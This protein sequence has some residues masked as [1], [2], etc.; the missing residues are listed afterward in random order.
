MELQTKSS[1]QKRFHPG[2]PR[3]YKPRVSLVCLLPETHL[4]Q[5]SA[6]LQDSII[7]N[8]KGR[9]EGR[10][11]GEERGMKEWKKREVKG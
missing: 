3:L 2:G 11:G 9:K 5:E 8:G 4:E 6:Q 7:Q 10:E 1:L